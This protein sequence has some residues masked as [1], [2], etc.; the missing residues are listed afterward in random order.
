MNLLGRKER[1]KEVPEEEIRNSDKWK[2]C[3]VS[4]Y[5]TS[6]NYRSVETTEH[7]VCKNGVCRIHKDENHAQKEPLKHLKN[8]VPF[9]RTIA[10]VG[11]A[12]AGFIIKSKLEDEDE[13]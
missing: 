7:A 9:S 11:A 4:L 8:D 3:I 12:V 10:V 2:K 13:D 5:L 1:I 6:N